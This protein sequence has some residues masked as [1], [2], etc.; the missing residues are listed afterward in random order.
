MTRVRLNR[1]LLFEIYQWVARVCDLQ[2]LFH[3]G[4]ETAEGHL[5]GV[6]IEKE[7]RRGLSQ[8]S[9]QDLLLSRRSFSLL[10]REISYWTSIFYMV[11]KR[12]GVL[13]NAQQKYN[14]LFFGVC[15][16]V[17][18][19]CKASGGI[20]HLKRAGEIKV[21][22]AGGLP[23]LILLSTTMKL[24]IKSQRPGGAEQNRTYFFLPDLPGVPLTADPSP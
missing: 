11:L 8:I 4:R 13:L 19:F 3:A 22:L 5:W 20:F 23:A 14:F 18:L 9:F 21:Q 15:L 16:K 12:R 2:S 17:Q 7:E 6:S 1:N 24:K 10:W